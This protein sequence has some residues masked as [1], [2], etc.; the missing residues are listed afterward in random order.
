MRKT[1]IAV[2]LMASATH[3]TWAQQQD[4]TET[5]EEVVVIGTRDL[6]ALRLQMFD[7]ERAAYELFNQLNDERRFDI[8]CSMQQPIGTQLETQLCQ[9]EFVIQ[10]QRTHARHYLENLRDFYNQ[11]AAGN[12]N[13]IENTPPVHVPMEALI[14]SQQKAYRR[15]MQEVAEKH[16]EFLE[17]IQTYAESRSQYEQARGT[18][19]K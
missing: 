12:P 8:S 14:A 3:P 2:A 6:M 17:A 11:A 9:P 16:P 1:G 10:A 4:T 7:A 15:K 5:P 13:P 19:E 18:A